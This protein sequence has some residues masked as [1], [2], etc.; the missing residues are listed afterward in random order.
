MDSKLPTPAAAALDSKHALV[1]GA[2]S[3][4]G[5]AT[6]RTL[7]GWG[8]RVT[9]LARR[10]QELLQLRD[11]L[12]QAGA[13]GAQVLVADFDKPELLQRSVDTW[14]KESG[15]AHILVHNTGGPAA[16]PLLEANANALQAAFRRHVVTAQLLTLSLLP[17]MQESGYGRIVN[18]LSTSVREPIDLLGVSN[19]I[20]AAMAAWA[21]SMSRELPPGVTI[22][23][24]LPGYTQT[25]RLDMLAR[26]TAERVGRSVDDVQTTWKASVPEARL[27]RPEEIAAAIAFLASPAASYVR[28]VSLAV[29]GGRLRSI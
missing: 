16:G 27:G 6:A 23:N 1:C 17:G 26:R 10:E 13:S 7:A 3:G 5:R 22:N 25:E 24:V 29:D 2:S 20:R 18:V 15:P 12:E 21:K 4:I 14:L 9:L 11:E 8:A 28:G 19:T